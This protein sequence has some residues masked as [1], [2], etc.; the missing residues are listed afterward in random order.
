MASLNFNSYIFSDIFKEN[1]ENI[2]VLKYLFFEVFYL[3][4]AVV[5]VE[6]A[7]YVHP[8]TLITKCYY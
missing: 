7:Q 5:E 6:Y 1:F 8:L 3:K 2:I 4:N